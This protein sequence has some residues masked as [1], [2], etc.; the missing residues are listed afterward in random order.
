MFQRLNVDDGV[1]LR[2]SVRDAFRAARRRAPGDFSARY[3]ADKTASE[4]R[5]SAGKK[6]KQ[7]ILK[8]VLDQFERRCILCESLTR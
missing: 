1:S 5:E 3:D 7:K 4:R 8:R 2:T 6:K